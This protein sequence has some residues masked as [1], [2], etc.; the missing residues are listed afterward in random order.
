MTGPPVEIHID[1]SA[2]PKACHTPAPIPIHW[3]LRVH[4][5]LIRDEELGIIE[6]VPYGDAVT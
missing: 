3:Q 1:E 2:K 6:K 5:Y 4:E